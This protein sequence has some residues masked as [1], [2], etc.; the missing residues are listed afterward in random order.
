MPHGSVGATNRHIRGAAAAAGAAA[1]AAA[2]AAANTAA[3]AANTAKLEQVDW[4]R[5]WVSELIDVWWTF[6][7][8][9][10]R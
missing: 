7:V 1:S 4:V 10:V 8:L 5:D 3:A 6:H 9:A 2:D